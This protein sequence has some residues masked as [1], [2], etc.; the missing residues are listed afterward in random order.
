[1]VRCEKMNTGP[2][3]FIPAREQ[4]QLKEASRSL[5]SS[6]VTE[7]QDCRVDRGLGVSPLIREG[8]L[9]TLSL[10]PPLQHSQSMTFQPQLVYFHRQ[11]SH[12]HFLEQAG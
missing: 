7:P 2:F 3:P 9:L 5:S 6:K 1:M 12:D 4:A 8:G 10:G 11:G